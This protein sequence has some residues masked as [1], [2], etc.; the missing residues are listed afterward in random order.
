MAIP[1]HLPVITYTFLTLRFCLDPI[2]KITIQLL[3]SSHD[4]PI[5]MLKWL[6]GMFTGGQ[7][8]KT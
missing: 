5:T 6:M 2:V 4:H 7:T 3:S 8:E 1:K